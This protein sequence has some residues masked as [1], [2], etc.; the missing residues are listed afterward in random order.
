MLYVVW[1]WLWS[2]PPVCIT[3]HQS[4]TPTYPFPTRGGLKPAATAGRS[5]SSAPLLC[6]LCVWG[7]CV[8]SAG[9]CWRAAI[10]VCLFPPPVCVCPPRTTVCLAWATHCFA[11]ACLDVSVS[12]GNMRL[13]DRGVALLTISA[14]LCGRQCQ[15]IAH[16][17]GSAEC[18]HCGL[19]LRLCCRHLLVFDWP[20]LCPSL[21]ATN[22]NLGAVAAALMNLAPG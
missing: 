19:E 5:F 10:L 13:H 12:V 3:A 21:L 15:L 6:C 9:I 8:A 4:G 17:S 11:H 14:G 1:A 22:A 16:D 2:C 7:T 20:A 18:R